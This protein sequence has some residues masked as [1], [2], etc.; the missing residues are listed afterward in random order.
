MTPFTTRWRQKPQSPRKPKPGFTVCPQ[1]EEFFPLGD[2][3]EV[4]TI[5]QRTMRVGARL[6]ATP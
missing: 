4:E 1:L 6:D 5:R 2:A 3:P